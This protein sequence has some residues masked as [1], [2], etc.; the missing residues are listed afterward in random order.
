VHPG[1]GKSPR[2]DR[3]RSIPPSSRQRPSKFLRF[4]KAS[5]KINRETRRGLDERETFPSEHSRTRRISFFLSCLRSWRRRVIQRNPSRRRFRSTR[6]SFRAQ[7]ERIERGIRMYTH[8][9]I[10]NRVYSRWL[11]G[12]S[13]RRG[14]WKEGQRRIRILEDGWTLRF[15]ALSANG[16][17]RTHASRSIVARALTFRP[18]SFPVVSFSFLSLAY[19]VSSRFVRFFFLSLSL[20]LHV[21]CG[22]TTLLVLS[23]LLFVR[24]Y[25]YNI[26]LIHHKYHSRVF[27]FVILNAYVYA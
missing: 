7:S 14:R 23:L 20:S 21:L 25:I 18:L 13:T 12:E 8:T 1:E 9:S 17:I 27:F 24:A 15:R 19:S 16:K 11:E 2:I 3:S 22:T 26:P 6:S 10:Y 4:R 5:L